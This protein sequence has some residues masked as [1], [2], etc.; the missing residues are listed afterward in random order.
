MYIWMYINIDDITS[1]LFSRYIYLESIR[2]SDVYFHFILVRIKFYKK[3]L[4]D[5]DANA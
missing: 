1:Y 4:L 2:S 3:L 5:I